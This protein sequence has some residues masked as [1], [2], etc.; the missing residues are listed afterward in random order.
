MLAAAGRFVRTEQ[1]DPTMGPCARLDI[2]EFASEAGGPASYDV[3][4]VTP[5][6]EDVGFLQACAAAPGHAA[7]ERHKGKLEAQYAHRLPG[8][9]LV[10]LVVEIGG[11]WHPSVPDLVRR[12]ARAHVDRTTGLPAEA[13][14]AVAGRWAA[15]LSA[16]LI[17]G[18][19]L[20]G[21]HVLPAAPAPAPPRE[22]GEAR[23]PHLL[24]E[25]PSA[26]ELLVGQLHGG[27]SA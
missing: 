21:R 16:L 20:V 13:V 1:R 7:A 19:A 18:S 2:V 17:R 25:G 4:V 22:V 26:Y 23:L 15:R 12:L 5:F 24:P 9:R 11:R 14:G 8:A 6:R 27:A 10:P 3:S